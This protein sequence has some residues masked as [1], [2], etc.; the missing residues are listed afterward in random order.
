[1]TQ[2]LH[3]PMTCRCESCSPDNPA[4]TYTRAYMRECLVREVMG[5]ERERRRA[6]YAAWAREHG[7]TSARQLVAEV[8]AAYRAQQERMSKLEIAA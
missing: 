3:P 4:P 8:N 2:V 6:F 5:Y 7:E 1:M